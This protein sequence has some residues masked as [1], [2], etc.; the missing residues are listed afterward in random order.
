MST[1]LSNQEYTKLK[2]CIKDWIVSI[3]REEKLPKGIKALNF[4]LFEPYG[5]ELIGAKEYDS[6]DDDWACEEDFVPEHR[7][8][9]NVE[10]YE[11]IGW[12][13][14]LNTVVQILVELIEELKEL[15]ILKVEHITTGF[16]DGDLVV[17]R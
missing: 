17:V 13:D 16:C 5:I 4:G 12:E 7:E 1:Q 11:D 3:N 9:P 14:F 8:C 10:V 6:E 2:Q 15:D